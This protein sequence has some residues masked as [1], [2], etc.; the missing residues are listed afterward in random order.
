MNNFSILNKPQ[1]SR[2]LTISLVYLGKTLLCFA[3]ITAK[4]IL[5]LTFHFRE[6][7]NAKN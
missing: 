5:A 3:G 1:L 4:H 6:N 7:K 2:Q